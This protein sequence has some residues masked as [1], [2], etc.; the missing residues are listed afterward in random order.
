[1]NNTVT[2]FFKGNL[3]ILTVSNGKM[4][5]AKDEQGYKVFNPSLLDNLSKI[6]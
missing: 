2:R 3:F 5:S 4:I 1:M 6:I